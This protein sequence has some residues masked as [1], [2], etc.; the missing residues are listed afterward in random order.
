LISP[1]RRHAAAQHWVD[2]LSIKIGSLDHPISTLS[3][4]NQQR[5]V[6]ARWLA[7]SPKV[8]ILDSPTV[9]VDIKNKIGIYDVIRALS[10]RGV[11]VIVISDEVM[12]IFATCDRVL[13]MRS[14]RLV[15]SYLPGDISEHALEEKI[16]A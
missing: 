5:V 12:E 1:S 2:E 16:Y 13:H 14:G 10:E 9:G 4:G 7:T 6:L 11:G 3:G 8:L 15:G